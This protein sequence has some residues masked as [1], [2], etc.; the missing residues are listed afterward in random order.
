MEQRIT[1]VFKEIFWLQLQYKLTL[2]LQWWSTSEN[3]EADDLTRSS[4]EENKR[5]RNKFFEK[6]YIRWGPIE[7]DLMASDVNVQKWQGNKLL[8]YSQY[9][10]KEAVGCDVLSFNTSF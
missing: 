2:K 6:L 8:F 7:V 4:P 10:V 3:Y 1:N 5:L 9:F